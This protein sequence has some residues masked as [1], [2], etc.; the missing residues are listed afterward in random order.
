MA[1]RHNSTA[2]L[3]VYKQAAPSAGVTKQHVTNTSQTKTHPELSS[4]SK[5]NKQ[6]DTCTDYNKL[7]V[8]H[9][10]CSHTLLL[11]VREVYS[12]RTLRT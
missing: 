3:Q 5:C 8:G 11:T 1:G 2:S 10:V 9:A 7:C 6:R 12:Q 4:K